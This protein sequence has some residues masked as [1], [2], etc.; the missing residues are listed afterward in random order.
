MKTEIA[1]E[2]IGWGLLAVA[3]TLLILAVLFGWL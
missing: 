2:R 3:A 1:A